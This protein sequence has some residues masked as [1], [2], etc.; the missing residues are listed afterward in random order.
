MTEPTPSP[1]SQL[2]G[3]RQSS[4]RQPRV[5]Q[6]VEILQGAEV[7]LIEHQGEVYQLRV[8]RQNKLILNK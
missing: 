6:S 4:T 1:G 2:P 8:T 5:W 7:V 3:D